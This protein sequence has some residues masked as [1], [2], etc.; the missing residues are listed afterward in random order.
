MSLALVMIVKNEADTIERCLQAALPHIHGWTIVDTGSTDGTQN[1]IEETLR[2]VP[3]RLIQSDFRGFGPSRTEAMTLAKGTADYLLLL[4]AD[5]VLHMPDPL[6]AL[7]HDCYHGRIEGSSLD[8]TLPLLVK[9]DRDWSY[10]GVAHSY[11]ACDGPYTEHTLP[12]LSVDDHSSTGPEKLKRDLEL[13]SAEHARDPLDARTAF[14]LAQTYYDL[15]RFPEAIAAYRYRANLTG[16]DE[17]TFYARYM[18]GVL[19]CEHVSAADGIRELLAAWE[20]RP[21]RIEPLRVIAN[22]ADSVA[23]KAN[24]PADRLFVHKAK[25]RQPRIRARDVSAVIVTRGDVDLDP[26]LETLPYQDV[27]VWDNRFEV[28]QKILG[29]YM[30]LEQCAHEIVYFQDDDVIFT[31]HDQLLAAY[32]PGRIVA[33]MDDPWVQACGYHDMVLLGAGSIAD[34]NLFWPALNRYLDEHPRDDDFL[35]ECDFIVG[36][37]VPW[38]RVDLGYTP[39][40]FAD[41]ADRL[42]RQ[43]WQAEAKKRVRERARALR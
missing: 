6:P 43:P 14:Y 40:E 36:T 29:R 8:Y 34:R 30:A 13:L 1:L 7:T 26:I 27:V 25:Y 2:G 17:E 3:G 35:L 39:R 9:G 42:Y 33:N 23:D 32:E 5:M 28:D 38:K 11:L 22:V 37:M 10:H 16:W 4:D 31:A 24:Y 19:L 18:L 41:D 12:G 20:S 21:Q 15:D